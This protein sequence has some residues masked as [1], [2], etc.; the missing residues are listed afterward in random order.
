MYHYLCQIYSSHSRGGGGGAYSDAVSIGDFVINRFL[1]LRFNIGKSATLRIECTG[2]NAV[3]SCSSDVSGYEIERVRV[4]NGLK[5]AR[6]E[7]EAEAAAAGAAGGEGGAS[8]APGRMRF[9]N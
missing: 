5:R 3:R 7:T 2:G 4:W 6:E 8:I 9:T 1:R